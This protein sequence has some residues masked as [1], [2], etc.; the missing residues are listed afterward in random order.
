MT[1][2]E[3][4][5]L[6]C[7]YLEGRLASSVARELQQ[8]LDQCK[9]CRIVLDAARRTLEVHF[10]KEPEHALPRNKHVAEAFLVGVRRALRR[11]PPPRL[12][13]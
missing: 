5:Q 9:D 8:H 7:E 10:D 12:P 1:C 3:T 6:I 2:R 11:E 4:M 13:G